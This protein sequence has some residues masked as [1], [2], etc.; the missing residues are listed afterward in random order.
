MDD[1]EKKEEDNEPTAGRG[2]SLEDEGG[3][4]EGM[5]IV[6]PLD[7]DHYPEGWTYPEKATAKFVR[8]P[9]ASLHRMDEINSFYKK[10]AERRNC[11]REETNS[12]VLNVNYAGN[13]MHQ[14]TIRIR[15]WDATGTSNSLLKQEREAETTDKMVVDITDV[16]ENEDVK[17]LVKF[18]IFHG[19]LIQVD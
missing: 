3:E 16:G 2:D 5:S 17:K 7:F 10:A 6:D 12:F 13:E 1:E 4:N 15:F 19:Y 8:N 14:S 18:L 11:Q 9:L